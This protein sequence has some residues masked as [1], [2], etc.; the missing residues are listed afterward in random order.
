MATAGESPAR[1]RACAQGLQLPW[2]RLPAQVCDR[3]RPHVPR[4][5]EAGSRGARR[6]DRRGGAGPKAGAVRHPPLVRPR[7]R[8]SA[9]A[10]ASVRREGRAKEDVHGL[11]ICRGRRRPRRAVGEAAVSHRLVPLRA[12]RARPVVEP[13]QRAVER[14][15]VR[16]ARPL[17]LLGPEGAV[18]KGAQARPRRRDG[19]GHPLLVHP[20]RRVIGVLRPPGLRVPVPAVRRVFEC[21]RA[22]CRVRRLDE[23]DGHLGELLYAGDPARAAPAAQLRSVRDRVRGTRGGDEDEVESPV[24]HPGDAPVRHLPAREVVRPPA[25]LGVDRRDRPTAPPQLRRQIRP[26]LPWPS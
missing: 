6:L 14:R 25:Q 9:N 18:S 5:R 10:A 7:R 17:L 11:R 21:P 23:A 3:R 20:Q 15:R 24:T 4:R 12:V 1:P 19:V 2:Q 22:A 13:P 16:D 8:G 26:A